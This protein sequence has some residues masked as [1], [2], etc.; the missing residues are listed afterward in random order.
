MDPDKMKMTDAECRAMLKEID[1]RMEDGCSF[2]EWDLRCW[3]EH[4]RDD[5]KAKQQAA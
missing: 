1:R 5:Q 2:D 4:Y 3:L